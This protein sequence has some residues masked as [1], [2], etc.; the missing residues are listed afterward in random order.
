[1]YY[2]PAVT[3]KLLIN[4]IKDPWECMTDVDPVQ[5]CDD[6]RRLFS[7]V[8][9]DMY[10]DV[11]SHPVIM[12]DGLIHRAYVTVMNREPR[13]VLGVISRA[14]LRNMILTLYFTDEFGDTYALNS[15]SFRTSG[16][17]GLTLDSQR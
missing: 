16:T 7:G 3:C 9:G 5:M 4:V 15:V 13:L 17:E 11:I 1:M 6:L 2:V 14:V 10:F 12:H 8:G